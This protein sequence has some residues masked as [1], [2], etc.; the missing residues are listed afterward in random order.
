MYFLIEDND[1]LLE[2]FNTIWDKVGADM[3]K[4]IDSKPVYNKIFLKTK[5]KPHG[6]EVTDFYDIEFPNVDS[7]HTCLAAISLN[8]ALKES[9]N[10]Y[11]QVLL[12]V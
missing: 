7:N 6:D 4:E 11:L 3:K 12:R 9:E 8:S 2:K 1:D 10:Y 5:T